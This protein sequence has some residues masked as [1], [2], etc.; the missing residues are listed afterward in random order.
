M[1]ILAGEWKGRAL[2]FSRTGIRPTSNKVKE[3]L[4]NILGDRVAD[5]RFLDLFAGTGAMGLEALSQ[6]AEH[7]IFVELTPGVIYQN[8]EALSA[9]GRCQVIKRDVVKTLDYFEKSRQQFDVIFLDPPYEGVFLERALNK[10]GAFDILKP[11]G[12]VIAEHRKQQTPRDAYGKLTL[13]RQAK[14]GDTI[15][16]FYGAS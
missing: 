14:Y 6:G 8:V 11:N 9:R 10:L 16:S 5:C 1:R 7:A 12:L 15:L 4:F 3:A 13:S 2:S